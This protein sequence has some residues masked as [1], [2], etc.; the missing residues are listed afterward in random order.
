MPFG[1][2][3][4]LLGLFIQAKFFEKDA[5]IG[6]AMPQPEQIRYITRPNQLKELRFYLSADALLFKR[7]SQYGYFWNL[8]F[9]QLYTIP[10][11]VGRVVKARLLERVKS[12]KIIG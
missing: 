2:L 6:H 3:A 12:D 11:I 9:W 10:K 5:I 1:S 4:R 7:F 8:F